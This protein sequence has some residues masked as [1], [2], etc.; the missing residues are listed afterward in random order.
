MSFS[1]PATITVAINGSENKRV[2]LQ[3]TTN[4]KRDNDEVNVS[5]NDAIKFWYREYFAPVIRNEDNTNDF[6]RVHV[7]DS[8]G[9]TSFINNS[10]REFADANSVLRFRV[11]RQEAA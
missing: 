4:V 9:A 7:S 2:R 5:D 10:T 1:K 6:D 3:V 11:K 8:S